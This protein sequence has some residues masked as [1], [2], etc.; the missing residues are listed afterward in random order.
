MNFDALPP[1]LNDVFTGSYYRTII[2]PGGMSPI[3]ATRHNNPFDRPDVSTE[4]LDERPVDD[5]TP[6]WMQAHVL[7]MVA[8]WG[9]AN[10]QKGL[11]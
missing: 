5:D 2:V 10:A 9:G 6:S 4:F 7:G 1:L 8:V 3:S 11:R